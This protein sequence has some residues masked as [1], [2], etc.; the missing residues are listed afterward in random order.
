[1]EMTLKFPNEIGQQIQKL[2]N[3]SEFVSKVVKD[4]LNNQMV[5]AVQSDS[6]EGIGREFKVMEWLRQVRDEHY[7]LLKGKSIEDKIA[8]YREGA[9]RVHQKMGVSLKK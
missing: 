8:F 2:P 7:E 1:M 6:K 9:R 4:A 5:K 3:P